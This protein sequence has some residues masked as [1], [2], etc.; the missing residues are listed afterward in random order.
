MTPIKA[1]L[2]FYILALKIQIDA[3]K[4]I[5]DIK[6]LE[7][8]QEEIKPLIDEIEKVENNAALETVQYFKKIED[9]KKLFSKK[10]TRDNSEWLSRSQAFTKEFKIEDKNEL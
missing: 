6:S 4:L 5:T 1:P 3:Q 9:S 2:D 8:T 10:N 7:Y